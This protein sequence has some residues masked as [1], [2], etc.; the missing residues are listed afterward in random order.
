MCRWSPILQSY[1]QRASTLTIRDLFQAVL[2]ALSHAGVCRNAI[3]VTKIVYPSVLE[4]EERVS[5]PPAAPGIDTFADLS[6]IV[7][8][9][10]ENL[11]KGSSKR[12]SHWYLMCCRWLTSTCKTYASGASN[13]CIPATKE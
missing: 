3:R 6:I 10:A 2:E 5:F 8:H 9:G 12:S 13:S 11:P 7:V 1:I 4:F